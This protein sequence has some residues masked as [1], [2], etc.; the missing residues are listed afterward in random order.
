MNDSHAS[1]SLINRE[2]LPKSP[3]LA[4]ARS[5]NGPVVYFRVLAFPLRIKDAL[6]WAE[7]NQVGVG[8]K[9]HMR[10]ELALPA[11][12][13]R[14]PPDCRRIAIVP[15]GGG[16]AAVS[17]VVATNKTVEDMAR[18]ED[19]EMIQNVQRVMAA[20]QPPAWYIPQRT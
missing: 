9:P 12:L 4:N 1:L 8:R 19:L 14:L 5:I 13:R 20:N 6:K 17:V 16:A 2:M 7:D 11:I 18:A 3:G 15:L 10:R